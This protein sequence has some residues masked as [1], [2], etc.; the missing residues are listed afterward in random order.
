VKSFVKDHAAG[1]A[2]LSSVLKTV[3]MLAGVLSLIPVIDV[4]ELR[5]RVDILR[6]AAI[7]GYLQ[8]ATTVLRLML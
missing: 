8:S 6:S 7:A 5:A 2:K 3:S 4:V 1:L